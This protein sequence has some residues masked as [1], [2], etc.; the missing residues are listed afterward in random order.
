M[1]WVLAV[2]LALVGCGDDGD[3]GDA[4]PRRDQGG[5]VDIR[6]SST[7]G[8]STEAWSLDVEQ[9]APY[10]V[11]SIALSGEAQRDARVTVGG[12]EA[13]AV[14]VDA[15]HVAFVVPELSLVTALVRV[16][17]CGSSREWELPYVAGA[18]SADP[19]DVIAETL[20]YMRSRVDALAAN[21]SVDPAAI[22]DVQALAGEAIAA[23]QG[24]SPEERA[25]AAAFFAANPGVFTETPTPRALCAPGCDTRPTCLERHVVVEVAKLLGALA[26]YVVLVPPFSTVALVMMLAVLYDLNAGVIEIADEC[27]QAIGGVILDGEP[28]PEALEV[29]NDADIE[30][31]LSL[32]YASLSGSIESNA[33]GSFPIVSRL[34]ANVAALA[35]AFERVG[36]LLRAIGRE[37][38][39]RAYSLSDGVQREEVPVDPRLMEVELEEPVPG[40]DFAIE[41]LMN[42]R[43]RLHATTS[44]AEEIEAVLSLRYENPDVAVVVTKVTIRVLPSQCGD[45]G[46]AC[47]AD[48][49]CTLGR[50]SPDDLCDLGVGGDRCDATSSCA[51]GAPCGGDGYC[52]DTLQPCTSQEHCTPT[53]RCDGGIC[54]QDRLRCSSDTECSA[55]MPTDAPYCGPLGR[56]QPGQLSDPC[57][58]PGDCAA[59]STYCDSSLALCWRLDTPTDEV[60]TSDAECAPF[61]CGVLGRC[62]TLN[63]PCAEDADCNTG[64]YCL[65]G[66]CTYRQPA[67]TT[68][69]MAGTACHPVYGSCAPTCSSSLSC[70]GSACSAWGVC[71]GPN[72]APCMD[73]A[74]CDSGFC[75][76]TCRPSEPIGYPCSSASECNGIACGPEG[77]CQLGNEREPCAN[78][79][80]CNDQP[81]DPGWLEPL[82]YYCAPTG[83]CAVGW[84]GDACAVD[85]QCPTLVSTTGF[86]PRPQRCLGGVCGHGIIGDACEDSSDCNLLG[87]ATALVCGPLERCQTGAP[88]DPC[89]TRGDCAAGILCSPDEHCQTGDVGDLCSVDVHCMSELLCGPERRC[90]RGVHGDPCSDDGDCHRPLE[91]ESF[92]CRFELCVSE[93]AP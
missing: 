33:E 22:A 52:H 31:D 86:A 63:G 50:C 21:R 45:L 6:D 56:C 26:A 20:A 92:E 66:T 48:R 41:P 71:G 59:S 47:C 27:M 51:G 82:R 79:A 12:V 81:L 67:C 25:R 85:S 18:A 36:E 58:D 62:T 43:Y 35:D 30:V 16:T 29:G 80:D 9:L 70:G 44:G 73:N 10:R 83:V 68:C 49:R 24:A 19:D 60:C 14:V 23:L 84:P 13:A 93:A 34:R 65:G 74:Q 64:F 2:L 77:G 3:A 69:M 40:L 17:A 5:E 57:A 1:R 78:D 72:G 54:V 46:A 38:R 87:D 11:V 37:I 91:G 4:S 55:V 7:S 76:G 28:A 89:L 75:S 32:E 90:Q 61:V 53:E 88:G 42:G 15:G 39:G 8:C